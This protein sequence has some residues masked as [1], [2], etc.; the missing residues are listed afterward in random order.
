M[1]PKCDHGQ[2][3]AFRLLQSAFVLYLA[4]IVSDQC[5]AGFRRPRLRDCV[6]TVAGCGPSGVSVNWFIQYGDC[7]T[8]VVPPSPRATSSSS[9]F[10]I[11]QQLLRATPPQRIQR[12]S[13]FRRSSQRPLPLQPD[14]QHV[15]RPRRRQS[16]LC[17]ILHGF[18]SD[19]GRDAL[20]L[21]GL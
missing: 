6:G 9:S 18:C 15:G 21:R 16:A 19:G 5:S 4:S 7:S 10:S 2:N 14:Q 13:Q 1:S 20:R 12:R 3:V 11:V 17:A 8:S